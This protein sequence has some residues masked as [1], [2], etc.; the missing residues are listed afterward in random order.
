MEE[1][2]ITNEQLARM[3]NKGF[4]NTATKADI[5]GVND[6]LDKVEKH[7]T[8]IEKTILAE[9]GRRIEGLEADMKAVKE[10]IG[11]TP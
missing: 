11:M 7:L 3:I 1:E 8:R 5:S 4:E 2:K 9:Q 6:R 10:A